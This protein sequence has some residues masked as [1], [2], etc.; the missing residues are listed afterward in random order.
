MDKMGYKLEEFQ[1]MQ[2]IVA[3]MLEYYQKSIYSSLAVSKEMLFTNCNYLTSSLQFSYPD[4]IEKLSYCVFGLYQ[5][6]KNMFMELQRVGIKTRAENLFRKKLKGIKSIEN[7]LVN[8]DF[9]LKVEP[10]NTT[11]RT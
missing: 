8:L 1:R 3:V 4:L 11:Y 10:S 2:D 5:T 6:L 9:G 7:L